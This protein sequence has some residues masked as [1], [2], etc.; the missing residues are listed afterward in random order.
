MARQVSGKTLQF[1]GD[2]TFTIVQF[3]DLHWHNGEES[4]LRTRRLMAQVLDREHPDLAVMTGDVISGSACLDPG[5]SW[6][7]S[8]DPIIERQIPWA[9]V[10]GNHEEE[11]GLSRHELMAA[12]REMPHCLAQPGPDGLT[13]VGNY[14]LTV[15]D[16]GGQ[17]RP[18]T[19]YLLDSNGYAGGARRR[20]CLD[21]SG[22]GCL[23]PADVAEHRWRVWRHSSTRIG[24]LSHTIARVR[25]SVAGWE[26]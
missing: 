12:Q 24:F 14:A 11:S 26:L 23:V 6:R 5:R 21:R 25:C 20:L 7:E 2:G 15:H 19:L 3:T 9:T 4:D 17:H 22:P 18:C 1:R 8:L 10:F 16:A 13:G